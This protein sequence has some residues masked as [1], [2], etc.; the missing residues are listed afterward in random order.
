MFLVFPSSHEWKERYNCSEKTKQETQSTPD[1]AYKYIH[2]Q[3][4][5]MR[6]GQRDAENRTEQHM[7]SKRES[8]NYRQKVT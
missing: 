2:T 1:L 6:Q 8:L 7:D 5:V 3:N 4:G